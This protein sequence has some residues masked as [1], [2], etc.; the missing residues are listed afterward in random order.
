MGF[1]IAGK[2]SMMRQNQ[3]DLVYSLSV[4]NSLH[5]HLDDLYFVDRALCPGK[6]LFGK[7]NKLAEICVSDDAQN[8]VIGMINLPE[9]LQYFFLRYRIHRLVCSNYGN[10]ERFVV[11]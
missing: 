7:F 8:H 11:K 6:I 5:V 9:S 1:F 2:R 3:I 10:P 4:L